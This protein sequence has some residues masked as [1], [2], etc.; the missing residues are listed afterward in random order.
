MRTSNIVNL[1]RHQCLQTIDSLANYQFRKVTTI[2][3]RHG[4]RHRQFSYGATLTPALL[5][6]TAITPTGSEAVIYFRQ[7]AWRN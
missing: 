3:L 7:T 2:A 4:G 6:A 5:S 1:R